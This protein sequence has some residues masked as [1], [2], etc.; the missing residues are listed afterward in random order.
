MAPPI[1]TLTGP[2]YDRLASAGDAKGDARAG[3]KAAPGVIPYRADDR[4]H[5]MNPYALAEIVAGQRVAWGRV[6]DPGALLASILGQPLGVLLDPQRSPMLYGTV[7]AAV[8]SARPNWDAIRAT[9]AGVVAPLPP[10]VSTKDKPPPPI[11]VAP[12]PG[13]ATWLRQMGL[14]CAHWNDADPATRQRVMQT[15]LGFWNVQML[16]A[17]DAYCRFAQPVESY[18]PPAPPSPP[19]PPGPVVAVPAAPPHCPVSADFSEHRG[20]LAAWERSGVGM[21]TPPVVGDPRQGCFG[22]C[23]FMAAL[24]AVAWARPAV[25]AA[26]ARSVDTR[27]VYTVPLYDDSPFGAGTRRDIRVTDWFP[28]GEVLEVEPRQFGTPLGGGAYRLTPHVTGTAP[29][30][31]PYEIGLPSGPPVAVPTLITAPIGTRPWVG[32]HAQ[33]WI[34]GWPAAFEKAHA[35]WVLGLSDGDCIDYNRALAPSV[36]NVFN[37]VSHITGGSPV[38]GLAADM[39]RDYVHRGIRAV[40]PLVAATNPIIISTDPPQDIVLDH[41]YSVLG[42]YSDGVGD[43]VVVRN[44]WGYQHIW[45]SGTP[46]RTRDA[47]VPWQG[48]VLGEGGVSAVGIWRFAEVFDAGVIYGST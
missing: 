8:A 24:A 44:P 23:Y 2:A 35:T 22:D 5:P 46:L 18:G 19:R 12:P 31:Q 9:R 1:F 36:H 30:G 13:P 4:R 28:R 47:R 10:A 17:I 38:Y 33:D 7:G 45:G 16:A 26:A 14:T 48:L 39:V 20:V 6:A 15:N 27:G 29:S 11:T 43:Y 21:L 37:S 32:A 41:V 34:A 40:V 42:Q 3:S 25:I